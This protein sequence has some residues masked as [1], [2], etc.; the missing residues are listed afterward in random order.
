[1]FCKY[2]SQNVLSKILSRYPQNVF[3]MHFKYLNYQ[4]KQS[5]RWSLFWLFWKVREIGPPFSAEASCQ[6]G[7]I[8]GQN[9][10]FTFDLTNVERWPRSNFIDH[11]HHSQIST[12]WFIAYFNFL[13]TRW[14][15]F[16]RKL[17]T[18]SMP[19]FVNIHKKL[20]EIAAQN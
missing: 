13:D 8:P 1:M 17:R 15:F 11:F 18:N 9:G 12:F 19:M 20:I 7:A 16:S 2:L 5:Q 14:D 6:V 4:T 10:A 3:D